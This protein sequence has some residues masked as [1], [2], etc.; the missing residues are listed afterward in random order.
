MVFSAF[1]SLASRRGA[2]R[3]ILSGLCFR[4]AAE[5]GDEVPG[6]WFFWGVGLA[7]LGCVWMLSACFGTRWWM[8]LLAVA[9]AFPL[10]VA[11]CRVTGET[12]ATPVGAMGKVTQLMFGMLA[13]S[14]AV[15]NI[16]T[17]GITS[18][19]AG[20]A[21]DLL[22]A[23]KTGRLLGASPRKQFL[24]Q[25]FGILAG[26]LAVVGAYRLLVP[27]A[28]ALG[29]PQWPAPVAQVWVSVARLFSSGLLAL[30]PSARWGMAAGSAAGLAIPALE[31]AFPRARAFLP[32]AACLG[33]AMVIPFS[34]SFTIFVGAALALALERAFPRAFEEHGVTASSG[35]IAGESLLGVGIAL[36][37][38]CGLLR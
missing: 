20:S 10:A 9:C 38:A 13:P 35:L 23:L 26:T 21:A 24:A 1:F 19:A 12:D 14:S 2:A 31:S 17:A 22:T 4:G 27:D 3:G 29:T 11:A 33:L 18:G 16:M 28:S 6:S 36:V 34:V 5:E 15:T 30:P 8:G 32:S 37:R 25:L 7:G